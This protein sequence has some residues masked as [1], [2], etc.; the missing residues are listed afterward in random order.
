MSPQTA[1]LLCSIL[2]ALAL[3]WLWLCADSAR[4]RAERS[5][6]EAKAREKVAEEH[7]RDLYQRAGYLEQQAHRLAKALAEV[8]ATRAA[9]TDTR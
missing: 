3:A 7:A 4:R 9:A 6:A 1:L 2:P 8:G 5:A